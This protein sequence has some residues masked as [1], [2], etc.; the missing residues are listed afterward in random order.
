MKLSEGQ[1][2]R[3]IEGLSQPGSGAERRKSRRVA[4]V[5]RGTLR[6]VQG[7]AARTFTVLTRDISETGMGLIAAAPIERGAVV[8]L[9]LPDTTGKGLLPPMRCQVRYCRTLAD[10]MW[11]I[12]VEYLEDQQDEPARDEPRSE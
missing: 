10:G 8:S 12:G 6:V 4:V 11:G 2:R 3:L 1:F 5:T 7:A 9:E